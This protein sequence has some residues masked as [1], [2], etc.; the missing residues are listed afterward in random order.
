MPA[1]EAQLDIAVIEA[2]LADYRGRLALAAR[3]AV[4]PFLPIKI[5]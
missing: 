1:K 4:K 5:H 2:L 3:D